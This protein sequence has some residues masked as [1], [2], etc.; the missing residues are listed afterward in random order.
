VDD[1]Y[2]DERIA[3]GYDRTSAPMFEPQALEPVVDVLVELA[4]GGAALEFAIGTGR[5]ALPLAERG[6]AVA[7]I[8]LSRAM[9]AK[10]REKPGGDAIDVEIGDM[11]TTRVEGSFSLVYLVF[12]T[13]MNLT[14]QA[15]QV[16]CFE[17][18]SAHLAPGGV[19][20]IEVGIPALQRL[21][22]GETIVP[23]DI[24]DDHWGVDEY[25]VVTQSMTSHHVEFVDGRAER[26]SVPFRYAFPAEYDLMAELAGLRLRERWGGWDREAFTAQSSTHVSIYERPTA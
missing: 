4:G 17:N 15:A 6:V 18:A 23:F 25:D 14:T 22:R 21:P 10:L 1:G 9:V 8:D 19:F 5:V 26:F 16:A 20:V 2:F 12:N 13:I 24:S 3:A 7:G 11:T